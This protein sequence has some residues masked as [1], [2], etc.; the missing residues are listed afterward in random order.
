MGYTL[1][2]GNRS[3]GV[4]FVVALLHSESRPF[5]DKC[6]LN[7]PWG[8]TASHAKKTPL[9]LGTQNIETG[10]PP[11]EATCEVWR[12]CLSVVLTF[13][14]LSL[15]LF[16]FLSYLSYYYVTHHSTRTERCCFPRCVTVRFQHPTSYR[17]IIADPGFNQRYTM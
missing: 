13:T 12:Y 1:V 11:F 15:S 4:G 3:A 14:T 5:L 16:S 10:F 9:C 8:F 7:P 6:L 17:Y 2:S